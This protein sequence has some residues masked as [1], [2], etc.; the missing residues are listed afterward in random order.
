M[1]PSFVRVEPW[2]QAG[3]YVGAVMSGLLLIGS[4]PFYRIV[5]SGLLNTAI[6]HIGD[7]PLLNTAR[8][9]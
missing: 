1:R 6:R 2:L 5:V 9:Q 4:S 3:K 8:F 7:S